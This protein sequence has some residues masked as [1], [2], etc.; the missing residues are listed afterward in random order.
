MV[1]MEGNSKEVFMSKRPIISSLVGGALLASA[2]L[3]AVRFLYLKE[4][5]EDLASL[6]YPPEKPLTWKNFFKNYRPR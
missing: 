2:G 4:T 6:P 1:I 5:K 3:A